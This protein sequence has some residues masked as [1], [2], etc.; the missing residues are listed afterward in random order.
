MGKHEKYPEQKLYEWLDTEIRFASL[1]DAILDRQGREVQLPHPYA[2]PKKIAYWTASNNIFE[3]RLE[4]KDLGEF[5]GRHYL[6][7]QFEINKHKDRSA[8]ARF[9]VEIWRDGATPIEKVDS[10]DSPISLDPLERKTAIRYAMSILTAA[11]KDDAEKILNETI[12]RRFPLI[13]ANYILSDMAIERP[14]TP[15]AVDRSVI[16]MKSMDFLKQMVDM[17]S[18]ITQLCADE[19]GDVDLDKFTHLASPPNPDLFNNYKEV[20]LRPALET[21]ADEVGSSWHNTIT[22][23]H[24]DFI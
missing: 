8:T 21:V 10:K 18:Y 12:E 13:A 6:L 3:Y 7:E 15:S 24:H 9:I 2:A 20:D 1:A 22:Q 4:K 16:T 19:E 11:A 14:G 5:G 23:S 17:E